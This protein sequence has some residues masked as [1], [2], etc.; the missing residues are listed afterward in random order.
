V[1]GR[2]RREELGQSLVFFVMLMTSLFALAALVVNLGNW[3]QAKRRAQG[4]VDAAVLA[5]AQEDP[6]ILASVDV[7][8][9]SLAQNWPGASIT[10][11]RS[12]LV[13]T[14]RETEIIAHKDV[15]IIF[16]NLLQMIGV[17]IVGLRI[18][19]AAKVRTEI[20][21][22]VNQVSP[23]GIFCDSDCKTDLDSG[24]F[25]W[26]PDGVTP[27]SFGFNT[28]PPPDWENSAIGPIGLP[29]VDT[30]NFA[31]LMTCD[32][33]VANSPTCNQQDA[34]TVNAPPDDCVLAGDIPPCY[35]RVLV[36]PDEFRA[37]IEGA[38]AWPHLVAIYDKVWPS[39]PPFALPTYYRVIGW[40]SFEPTSVTTSGGGTG[41]TV[42]GTFHKL[43]ITGSRLDDGPVAGVGGDGAKYDFGVRAIGLTA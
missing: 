1:I 25:P 36:T 8:R 5:G 24:T 19:A 41:F 16:G 33:L 15:P 6:N 22:L 37:A 14:T 20:P 11:Y 34:E 21:R 9:E 18:E 13:D 17:N 4:A 3:M 10:I 32:P 26:Q 23:L 30:T 2:I 29:G 35:R 40:A 43:N 27:Y 12:Q 38:G 28:G 39:P 42:T 7:A 31:T